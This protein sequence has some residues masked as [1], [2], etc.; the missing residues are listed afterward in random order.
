MPRS[1]KAISPVIATVIII[2]VTLAIAIAVAGWIMGLWGTMGSTESL[3]I[4]PDS[5]IDS[6]TNQTV[7]YIKNTGTASAKIYKVEIAGVG[8]TTDLTGDTVL[9]PGVLG[10]VTV[11][12]NYNYVPG[13]T[14][15]IKVYTEAG[16]VYTA[17]IMAK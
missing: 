5:Y 1:R 10:T 13:Q 14:Y 17:T 2:A 7:L 9:S 15:Q 4:Y 11:K 12:I 8:T 3:Q 6:S 16:N